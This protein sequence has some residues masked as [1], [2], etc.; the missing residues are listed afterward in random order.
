MKK[1]IEL[2]GVKVHN[3]KNV[4]LSIDTNK[5]IVFTG[6]S[7]SG[8]SSLAFDTIYVE[9]QRRYIESL[10]HHARRY[11]G[12]LPKPELK[13]ATGISPTI[14]IEQKLSGRSP[15]STVGTM[16]GIYDFFRI[17]YA[18][19]GVP[20][21][22]V[23]G[24]AVQAQS[25]EKILKKLELL[26][27]GMRLLILSPYAKGKKG[28][29]KDDFKELLQKGFTR[30]RIDGEI[31]ELTGDDSLDGKK[32]HDV[33]IVIDRLVT[34]KDFSRLKEAAMQALELGKG[35]FSIYHVDKDDEKLFSEFAYSK[36]SGL[37]YGPLN[38]SDFSFNHP[39]G[40]CP[41]CHG[42]G[43]TYEFDLKKIIEPDLSISEDCCR[44]A[45]SYQTVRYGNVYDNLA[46]EFGFSV[47]KP[48]QKLSKE[49]QNVFLNGTK[50]KWTKMTFRHPEKKTK[51]TE[52]VRWQGVLH[53]AH[54]R[55]N[56][57]KSDR[58]RTK[59]EELM[60]LSLCPKCKGAKIR[61]YPARAQIG[62]KEIHE[63]TSMTLSE[64]T[65]FFEKLKLTDE[66]QFIAAEVLKEVKKRIGFLM[67]V[68]LTYLTLGRTSPT[69]SGGEA[70]RVRLASQ[71]GSGLIGSTYI[72]D[73]PSIGLHP[74]DHG[75]LIQTL[76]DLRDAGNTVLVV[77]HDPDTIRSADLVVD[78]GPG[79]GKEGGEILVSGTYDA[80][81]KEPRSLTGKYMSGELEIKIP[82]KK[83]KLK[84]GIK[85]TGATHHN[86]KN[87]DVDIPL[88]GLVCVTGVS[89]SGK[90]SLISDILH[91]ALAN[92]FHNAKMKIGAHK[93]IEGLNKIDKV[94]AIDQSP[95]GRTPRSNAATYIKLF[96]HI[97][98]LYSSLPESKMRGYEKGH[99]SFNVKEGSCPYCSGVG[100]VKIDMDFMEDIWTIC[101][102]CDGKRFESDI[103]TITFN[104]K[105]IFDVLEM[106]VET[107]LKHFENIPP[108]R[109][110]LELLNKVGLHYLSIGQPSPTL[111]GGEAQRIKLAKELVRPSTGDTLYIL[112]EPTTG[113]HFH[114]LQKLLE[115]IHNLID[116]GNTAIVIEHNMDFIKTAD[117]IIDIG[118]LAGKGGGELNGAG[119]P[120]QIAKLD[121]PTGRALKDMGKPHT[122][123][124]TSEVTECNK[125]I[126]KGASENNLK[127]IDAQIKQGEIT[128]FTGPSG[129]GKTSLAFDTI[130]AEGQRRYIESLSSYAKGFLK[131]P[132]KP[133]AHSIEGLSPA[134]A[135]EQNR[136]AVNPRS[137]IG[138]MTEIYDLLRIFYAHLGTAYA[139]DT[140]NRIQTI[141]KEFVLQKVMALPEKTKIHVL[142]PISP[143][144][145]EGFTPFL[146]RL[147]K[148][149]FIRI[150]L[151]G[152]YYELED[153][154]PFNRLQKNAIF[155]VIDRLVI[156]P[157]IEARLLE[158]IN[159]SAE[160]GENELTIA[161]KDEDLYF[162]LSFA[163]PVT[164][165]SY[166]KITPQTFSFNAAAGMCPDCQ[167][168]GTMYGLRLFE[169]PK[170]MKLS[171][172]GL[173]RVL[174]KKQGNRPSLNLVESYFEKIKIDPS[175]PLQDLK[176]TD[177]KIFLDGSDQI[178]S[179]KNI[180][181]RWQGLITILSMAAKSAHTTIKAP[182]IPLMHES[183]CSSCE[184]ARLNPLARNVRIENLSLTDFCSLS[185][186]KEESF[187]QTLKGEI[188]PFLKESYEDILK[189]LSFLQ[190]IGLGYLSLERTAPSLSGGEL[191]RIRLS[192][193]LGSGLTSCIYVL[194]E[195]TIGL[196]PH[197][198]HLLNNA[199]KKLQSLGNTLILVE[200]DPMTIQI[201]DTILD[202][203]PGAGKQGGKITAKGSLNEILTDPNSLTGAYLSGKKRIEL[204]KYRRD[205]KK[206]FQI[207]EATAHNL[208][209]VDVEIPAHAFTCITGVSGSGKS[210]LLHYAIKPAV[211]AFFKTKKKVIQT[212]A[213]KAYKLD[214]FD[215]LIVIDQNV[216]KVSHRSD[217]AS[218]SES[219]GPLRF[220]YASLKKAKAKGL[221]PI[222][223]SYHHKKGMCKTCWG[224]GYK[225][226][227][228]QFL[229][230]VKITCDACDGFKLN[231]RSLEVT[232]KEKHLGH[233]LKMTVEEA[234]DH[235]ADIPPIVRK[236]DTL[237]RVG[238]G[239]LHLGQE[240]LSLSG[241]EAQRIR[242]SR[243]LSKRATAKTLYLIDEPTTG[244][245]SEDIQKLLKIFHELV[246][247]KNTIIVIEHN[248]DFIA[249]ADYII[250][251]GPEAGEKGGK[252][253][254]TG[255][256]EEVSKSKSFT[257]KY[258]KNLLK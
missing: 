99:F 242:L 230:A 234:R 227:D 26:P 202:F 123:K 96:D 136:S 182:L 148:E 251:I 28:E 77:E 91:P 153:D 255:T 97:R 223:F 152:T 218:Y 174:L 6:V 208:K 184:G 246:D 129:S 220:F 112:D 237:I 144:K 191:Q 124:S 189:Q 58:Y 79:A 240:I 63:L 219:L 138:T 36:K 50:K 187:M 37:S 87:V 33:D 133:K 135:I 57:A 38:P 236:L 51:W 49:A 168:L 205:T 181:F 254:A 204:P 92:H 171:I 228:L 199:L 226:I 257:S 84:K 69:L 24:E 86:L 156:G 98:D 83:R 256:P 178:V 76:F 192:R 154:I 221:K 141:S 88:G 103:L 106:D 85:I 5:L 118:P 137:T 75:K 143:L 68:G 89:G 155:L 101:K 18:R 215:K 74:E 109:K 166:S 169:N 115:L 73:E 16:T 132:P 120:K 32:A 128:V 81:T 117:Y 127:D 233:I 225:R 56:E 161:L 131:M 130:Y 2:K 160:I 108:I 59:M 125:I 19:I 13:K 65:E 116:K 209:S 203:G 201:A 107:A 47:K 54:K 95:I 238:L 183:T 229:P 212:D 11:L 41:K 214:L 31:V 173:L 20:H 241:G 239:Y 193:Q 121:T 35:F 253:V 66:D 188:K 224:L 12:D 247:K 34:E 157:N 1:K 151:N 27:V 158:A 21:C 195:P 163:D 122:F 211:Q 17:L 43:E 145:S 217:V 94:I 102:Q 243:E 140:G 248:M 61:D 110:K 142:A 48:W 90:S 231:P 80:L 42:L 252:I 60:T 7:G 45:S 93:K 15:R 206:C 196:H 186:D 23:S 55:L 9:G 29:F 249:N 119:T 244:L 198:N 179:V 258:L 40:M 10:S 194:D 126:I 105:N 159:K 52:F 190:E 82:K 62:G 14:A 100:Q 71:V 114:D 222:R 213:F 172:L 72:L 139:P 177:L 146:E 30:V 165:K 53:E 207:K 104:E 235:F 134:I 70:Q 39:N 64:L 170:M 200:H 175:T 147:Q 111:S 8:K 22:P 149:G 162:N 197:N 232:Y 210:S 46:K 185:I 164:G 180:S 67:N 3:L 167:G 176:P 78:V 216:I 113:L 250:D 245:H 44:I 4:D 25:R 150:R